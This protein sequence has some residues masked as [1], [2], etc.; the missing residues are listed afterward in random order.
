MKWFQLVK[1]VNGRQIKESKYEEEKNQ[2]KRVKK[3]YI[4]KIDRNKQKM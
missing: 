3:K 2:Q 1:R 4:K